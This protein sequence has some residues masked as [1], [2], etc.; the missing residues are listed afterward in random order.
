MSTTSSVNDQTYTPNL[1]KMFSKAN[2]NR[3]T[4]DR[5]DFPDEAGCG[6]I[7]SFPDLSLAMN[8]ATS[9]ASLNLTRLSS[10]SDDVKCDGYLTNFHTHPPRSSQSSLPIDRHQPSFPSQEHPSQPHYAHHQPVPAAYSRNYGYQANHLVLTALSN[11]IAPARM[12]QPDEH[13]TDPHCPSRSSCTTPDIAA[14]LAAAAALGASAESGQKRG[15]QP[16]MPPPPPRPLYAAAP[17]HRGSGAAATRRPAME[18]LSLGPGD[19]DQTRPRHRRRTHGRPPPPP[20][21]GP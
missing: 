2:C 18:A 20:P 21:A 10:P 8:N 11:L 17:R 1:E 14:L 9:C 6:S 16:F 3:Q 12:P 4:V 7:S 5:F 15:R 19:P 13:V